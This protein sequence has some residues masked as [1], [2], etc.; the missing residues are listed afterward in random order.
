M[1]KTFFSFLVLAALSVIPMVTNAHSI[2]INM[3][4]WN[5]AIGEENKA[6]TRMYIGWGHRFPVDGVTNRKTFDF[7]NLVKP[8]GNKE[9]VELDYE[10]ISTAEITPSKEGAY[11][12]SLTRRPS[13]YNTY[14]ENGQ[15]K[16][17]YGNRSDFPNVIESLRTQQF[18]TSHFRVGKRVH[19]YT[20]KRAGNVL[21]LVP[22]A[23]P[24]ALGKNYVGD[25][26]PVQLLLDGKPVPYTEVTAT[27]AGFSSTD[28]MAQRLL[29]DKN[30]IA[31]VRIVHWG[32]WLLKGKAERPATGELAKV[33]DKEVYYTTLTFEI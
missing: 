10:G 31:Y 23:D 28:A 33:A 16:R 18:S 14:R 1:L 22:L 30:G 19:D 17:G 29:T 13:V 5:P 4:N 7:I 3:S 20:P 21:E 12:L 2:W 25:L 8:D 15:I 26:L 27:Y 11:I 24:Y 32:E 9:K 6:W